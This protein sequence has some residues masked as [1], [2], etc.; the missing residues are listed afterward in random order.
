MRRIPLVLALLLAACGSKKPD[1]FPVPET[2]DAG[3]AASEELPATL[4]A[5]VDH[6]VEFMEAIAG[7][8]EANVSDCAEM[9]VA[10]QA[11]A[12]GPDGKVLIEMDLDPEYRAHS[13]E[14]AQRYADRL[15]AVSGRIGEAIKSCDTQPVNDA[16]SQV[17]LQ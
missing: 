2:P 1:E 10:L 14:V 9:G 3:A 15:G 7:A 11:L 12:D 5:R 13:S 4:V 16:L 8:A 17:G 6:A